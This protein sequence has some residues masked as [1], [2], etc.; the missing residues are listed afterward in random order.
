MGMIFTKLFYVPPPPPMPPTLTYLPP[1]SN[2]EAIEDIV[3][4]YLED[5]KLTS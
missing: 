1:Y 2:Q 4:T 3:K 5:K